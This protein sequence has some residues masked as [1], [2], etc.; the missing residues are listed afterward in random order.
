[1]PGRQR[2]GTPNDCTRLSADGSSHG[3]V[4][5]LLTA[6]QATAALPKAAPPMTAH[7]TTALPTPGVHTAATATD[8]HRTSGTYRGCILSIC[9]Y[10]RQTPKAELPTVGPSDS[11]SLDCTSHGCAPI[12]RLSHS[13]MFVATIHCCTTHDC[14]SQRENFQRQLSSCLPPHGRA[15]FFIMVVMLASLQIRVARALRD[16][17]S[18]V[19]VIGRQS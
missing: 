13:C 14:A 10:R 7:P 6:A 12:V 11:I 19:E 1:M 5:A 2:G 16:V 17:V 18:V 4:T 15:S 3:S 9:T 8:A